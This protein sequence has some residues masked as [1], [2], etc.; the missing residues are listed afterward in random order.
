MGLN[1]PSSGGSSNGWKKTDWV[2]VADVSA[3]GTTTAD[4]AT[5]ALIFGGLEDFAEAVIEVKYSQSSN[6]GGASKTWVM[7]TGS[8]STFLANDSVA[9]DIFTPSNFANEVARERK[10]LIKLSLFQ[11]SLSYSTDRI[12]VKVRTKGNDANSVSTVTNIK[13][14]LLYLKA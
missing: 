12:A 3:T 5:M 14:R 2:S 11:S 7:L 8:S 4:S 9:T 6:V 13:A 10:H 1:I